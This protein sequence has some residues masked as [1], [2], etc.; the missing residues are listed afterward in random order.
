VR[1]SSSSSYTRVWLN[2][3]ERRMSNL[4][5]SSMVRRMIC[6]T[7]GLVAS[8]LEHER[9]PIALNTPSFSRDPTTYGRCWSVRW[10]SFPR[11]SPRNGCES[12]GRASSCCKVSSTKNKTNTRTTMP[13]GVS[14]SVSRLYVSRPRV[15]SHSGMKHCHKTVLGC[16][17]K[18]LVEFCCFY[19]INSCKCESLQEGA[20][21]RGRRA[22]QPGM[23]GLQCLGQ[24]E[25]TA[26][27]RVL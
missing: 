14:V 13:E 23:R 4:S 19:L 27:G 1:Y 25:K 16:S 26:L 9:T 17:S 7:S 22:M 18:I 5:S 10:S 6:C 11:M 21:K 12:R 8:S 20:R 3:C 15:T 2:S 24:G